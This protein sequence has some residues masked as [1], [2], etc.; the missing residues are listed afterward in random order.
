MPTIVKRVLSGSTDGFPIN[1]SST[2]TSATV[3]HT[4]STSTNVIDEVW[5]YAQNSNTVTVSCW[6]EWG[7][8]ASASQLIKF[9]V[10]GQ[11]GP[12]CVIPGLIIQGRSATG[13]S[14][15]MGA[16]TSNV[17]SILGFVNRITQ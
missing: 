6:M 11:S 2:S 7:G 12:E 5:L 4:G 15:T 17:I 16:S 1:V 13:I 14:I 10:F 3:I 9:D 8:G